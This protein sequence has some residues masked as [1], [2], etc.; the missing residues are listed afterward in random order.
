[1]S[2]IDPKEWASWPISGFLEFWLDYIKDD[3]HSVFIVVPNY[4]LMGICCIWRHDTVSL[5]RKLCWLIGLHE[6]KDWR[7]KFLSNLWIS[8]SA[9]T[10]HQVV[11]KCWCAVMMVLVVGML[12]KWVW[13]E[14]AGDVMIG[15]LLNHVIARRS[16][17]RLSVVWMRLLLQT[18]WS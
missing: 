6:L 2:V 9:T 11:V 8:K 1:M 18:S 17:L 13:G 10:E 12:D 15:T 14:T 3:R 7:I 4:P 5:A 16:V